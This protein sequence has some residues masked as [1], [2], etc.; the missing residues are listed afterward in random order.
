MHAAVMHMNNTFRAGVGGVNG[1]LSKST[2]GF[3]QVI[4]KINKLFGLFRFKANYPKTII[5]GGPAI[6]RYVCRWRPSTNGFYS[7]EGQDSFLLLEFYH[8]ISSPDFPRMFLDV[9][10]N[11]PINY[12]NSYFFEKELGFNVLAIDALDSYKSTWQEKR[13]AAKYVTCAVGEAPGKIEFAEEI[14]DGIESMFSSVV[15]YS[16]KATGLQK[17]VRVLSVNTIKKLLLESAINDVGIMSMDIEG[18]E[19]SALKGIDF[20]AVHFKLILVENNTK[21]FFGD[22]DVRELLL[23]TGY[24]FYARFWGLDDLFVH[25]SLLAGR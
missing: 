19:V 2:K 15:G 10:C 20:S 8:L 16:D 12:N 17:K 13:P 9:G 14:G 23:S 4:S 5:I 21:D 1:L 24:V 18:Y 7:Q 3:H 22:K 25:K 6:L 11:H